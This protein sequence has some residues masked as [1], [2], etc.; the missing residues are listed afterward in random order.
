[1]KQI[2]DQIEIG[3]QKRE[4]EVIMKRKHM[5][6]TAAATIMALAMNMTVLAAGWQKDSLG[7]WWQQEDGTRLT[8]GWQWLDGN[9]DGI[10]ECYYF[11]PS[12]YMQADITTPDGYELNGD[13]AW[14]VDGIVQTKAVEIPATK[15]N[16][17]EDEGWYNEWG[18]N[19]AALDMLK[20]SREE[21]AKYGEVKEDKTALETSVYYANGFLV[22]Y[23]DSAS[24]YKKVMAVDQDLN[25]HNEKLFQYYDSKIAGG[26]E[27]E[28][29]LLGKGWIHGAYGP[30]AC[31]ADGATVWINAGDGVLNWNLSRTPSVIFLRE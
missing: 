2:N 25:F 1:M 23:P 3:Y 8:G 28:D 16:H 14:I 26:K 24:F 10:A 5:F 12:G 21:N 19:N 20:N 31:Y 22:S 7:W 9:L 17:T 15:Q 6:I 11:A 4:E 13:G 30:N 27:A 18:L 29:Y